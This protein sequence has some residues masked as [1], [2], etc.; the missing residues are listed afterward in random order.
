MSEQDYDAFEQLFQ[1]YEDAT[2][3]AESSDDASHWMDVWNM[4]QRLRDEFGWDG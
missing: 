2:E 3:R 4:E 1:R